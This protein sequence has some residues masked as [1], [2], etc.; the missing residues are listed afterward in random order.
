MAVGETSGIDVQ[1]PW[2]GDIPIETEFVDIACQVYQG[3]PEWIPEDPRQIAY[4]FSSNH[5]YFSFG[6][7]WRGF[8]KGKA[9]IAGFFN[10]HQLIDGK[11]C[12]Y[13]GFWET[14]DDSTVNK[15]LFSAFEQW[16]KGEG[17]Q[18]IYGPINFNTYGLYRIRTNDF[19]KPCFQG[20]PYNPSYYPG[21]L[22]SLGYSVAFNYFSQFDHDIPRLVKEM[23]APC[24]RSLEK[25]G[26]D[27]EV[28]PLT[29]EF[30]MQNLQEIYRLSELVFQANFAYTPI[31]FEIFKALCGESFIRKAHPTAS[32]V[33]MD[34]KEHCIAGMLLC[35]PSWGP[36]INQGARN[37]VDP[38]H[39]DY[40]THVN[41]LPEP[42]MAL[43]KTTGVDPRYRSK[44][45]Y[46]YM[47]YHLTK[48]VMET[49][50]TDYGA[51][52]VKED[53]LSLGMAAK[54]AIRRTYAL[55]WK[56]IA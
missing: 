12:A 4:L 33:V 19:G 8:V 46:T 14:V 44:G 42:K 5:T 31:N 35:F 48:T 53:N 54:A 25:M 49:G 1:G 56:E 13:F 41:L 26:D 15:E 37:R 43:A 55:Y 10:P 11:R 34:K 6:K 3:D 2:A 17:A 7:V 47:M 45:L 21:L 50:F 52:L 32:M 20:E 29:P 23:E 27:F 22:E 9:R 30:W 18:R 16:A 39:I 51:V 38:A 24:A 28:H 36:L 40:S